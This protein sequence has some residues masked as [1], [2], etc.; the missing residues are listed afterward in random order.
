MLAVVSW[1]MSGD[2]PDRLDEAPTLA[3][4]RFH[5]TPLPEGAFALL[6]VEG[7]D[8]GKNFPFDGLQP[9]RLL[10]GTSPACDLLVTDREVSRRHAALELVG[11]RIRVT[12]LGSKNGTFVDG[13]A[14]EEA[15]MQGGE[16]L[17]MGA[18]SFRIERADSTAP[19]TLPLAGSFGRLRGASTEM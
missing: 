12:D 10:V 8:S 9:S 13:I 5:P 14:V 3:R 1:S 2:T 7:P 17:R 15:Y 4:T 19:V 16:V 11:R 6:V 18:T